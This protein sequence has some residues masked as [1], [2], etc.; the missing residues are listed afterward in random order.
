MLWLKVEGFTALGLP[1]VSILMLA[2]ALNEVRAASVPAP[3]RA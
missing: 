2:M 1:L 3:W